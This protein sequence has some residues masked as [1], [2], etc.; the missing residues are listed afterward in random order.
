MQENCEEEP[1]NEEPESGRVKVW[2]YCKRY[3][4]LLVGLCIMS[5][6]VDLSIKAALGTS[7]I[8]GIPYVLNLITGLSGGTTTIIVNVMIVI[9][10]IVL[11]RKKFQVIQLLQIPVCI[12]FGLL[13]RGVGIK[14]LE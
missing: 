8:S 7:P 10:Q 13:T 6:G 12:I 11:L 14:N 3:L 1:Q 5:V 2:E 4:F 9:L